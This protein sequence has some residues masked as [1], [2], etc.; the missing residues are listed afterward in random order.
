M[1]ILVTGSSGL[2]GGKLIPRLREAGHQV[3][4]LVRRKP[5]APDQRRWNPEER[6]DPVV[7]DRIDTVIH[8]AGDNIAEGR[9][10]EEKKRQIRDSRVTGTRRLAEAIAEASAPPKALVCASAIGYYGNRGDELLDEASPP[11]T[12]FLPD[13]CREWEAAAEPARTKGVRVAHVRLGVVLSTEGGALAKM[14]LP[15]KMGVGGVVGNGKQ[16]WSCVNVDDA[17]GAFQYAAENDS[18]RGPVNAVC[19]EPVTNYDFTKTLGRILGRP[20]LFPLPAT[21]ARLALGQMADDLLLASARVVPKALQ[22][23]GFPFAHP[24]VESAIR[25]ALESHR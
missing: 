11:G 15:F 13:V 9:W 4:R 22:E 5:T 17:V 1:N 25:G 7:L 3:F 6:V 12:G 16:Y 18:I 20:T 23:A 24:T 19:P 8:L 10:T 14:L 21:M 2:I